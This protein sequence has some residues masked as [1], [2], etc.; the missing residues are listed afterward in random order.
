MMELKDLR[1]VPFAR[2]KVRALVRCDDKYIFIQRQKY[3]KRRKFLVFP[4]GRLKKSD[5][6]YD[7]KKN[8]SQTLENGLRRELEEELCAKD[9]VIEKLIAVGN[10]H[11]HDIEVL[12]LVSISSFDW[13]NRTGKEFSNPHKGT[14]KLVSILTLNKETLGK[15]GFNLK[16][17][18]WRKLICSLMT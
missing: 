3:G 7:D 15:N 8:I 4:G 18:K 12:Y 9:V 14:Y 1:D 10:K 17:K 11:E 2:I 16:P 5:R 13:E 6:L